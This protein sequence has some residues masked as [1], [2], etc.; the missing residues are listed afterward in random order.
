MGDDDGSI[1]EKLDK[2]L[3]TTDL[4]EDERLEEIRKLMGDEAEEDGGDGGIKGSKPSNRLIGKRGEYWYDQMEEKTVENAERSI[5][6]EMV[7]SNIDLRTTWIMRILIGLII[8]VL[9]S[10]VTQL[11]VF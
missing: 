4:E 9:A 8:T 2:L 1:S 11:L 10:Y 7:L 5:E 3:T 6:N